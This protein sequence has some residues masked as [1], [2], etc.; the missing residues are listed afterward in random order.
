[1]S[2]TKEQISD[3]NAEA[4]SFKAASRAA[5]LR[6]AIRRGGGNKVVAGLSGVSLTTL[7]N[8]LNGTPMKLD[9]ALGI[10]RACGVSVEWLATGADPATQPPSPAATPDL[11]AIV[12]M[13]LLGSAIA[14]AT[15]VLE[16]RGVKAE[17]R[18][19]AQIVCLLYDEG[20]K[21]IAEMKSQ[22]K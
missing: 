8:Y 12:D 7:Q 15:Q 16:A 11:F 13:D 22:P 6:D 10:A 21:R 17:G 2:E 19:F 3:L 9:A 5:R 20:R 18:G 14:G 1:M 4:D